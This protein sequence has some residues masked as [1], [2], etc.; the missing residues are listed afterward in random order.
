VQHF[1]LIPSPACKNLVYTL[2]PSFSFAVLNPS[3]KTVSIKSIDQ[4][5]HGVYT[6]TLTAEPNGTT[7]G[8]SASTSFD[9]NLVDLCT[10]ATFYK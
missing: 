3:A 9:L 10:V 1:S 2:S 5:D 4:K 6:F 7:I 8:I